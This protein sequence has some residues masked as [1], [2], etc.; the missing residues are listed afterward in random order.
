MLVF[1]RSQCTNNIFLV[2]F[3]QNFIDISKFTVIKFLMY[4]FKQIQTFYDLQQ[5]FLSLN[6]KIT[7]FPSQRNCREKRKWSLMILINNEHKIFNKLRNFF[8]SFSYKKI[9]H[10][11]VCVA[12]CAFHYMISQLISIWL[13][14]KLRNPTLIE[15]LYHLSRCA[16]FSITIMTAWH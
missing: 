7:C 5:Y 2:V 13:G 11:C 9:N 4:F 3:F 16:I 12:A 10:S 6:N 1:I 8:I 15:T 14:F